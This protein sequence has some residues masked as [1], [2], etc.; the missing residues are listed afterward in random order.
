[1]HTLQSRKCLWP[2][3]A[4]TVLWLWIASLAVVI[5][6][7]DEPIPIPHPFPVPRVASQRSDRF[8]SREDRVRIYMSNW[9]APPCGAESQVLYNYDTS[10]NW[11]TLW[12][13]EPPNV[14]NNQSEYIMESRIEPDQAFFLDR[15]TLMDCLTDGNEPYL[16]RIVFRHNMQMYCRDVISSVLTTWDHTEWET[17]STVPLLL[18]FGD[19][20]YSHI[21]QYLNL[22]LIK[23]FRSATL[24]QEIERVSS[25][26]CVASNELRSHIETPHLSTHLQPIVWKLATHRHF[27]LLERTRAEDTP[28]SKKANMAIFLGQLTGSHLY[29]RD[30]SDLENC[31]NMMRCRLVY[32]HANST[33][34]HA[35]LTSTRNRM[36]KVLNGVQ[37]SRIKVSLDK[38]LKFKGIIMLEGNDVASGLK[39]ALLSQSVVLM[40]YPKHT[41]WA[42][43]ELL[44]P[45]VHYVPLNENATDVEEKMKWVVE[46][47]EAARRISERGTLWMEDLVFH[48]DAQEDDRWIQ[49]EIIRR[50]KTHFLKV[51][52]DA[53]PTANM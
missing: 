13:R 47:D 43:E 37:M 29:D 26:T 40:P 46:N 38:L 8:P 30:K 42:M 3:C 9:Y 17:P 36:P 49:E 19:L 2:C 12:I 1:M 50:Y 48:P 25:K 35:K 4:W 41:S 39:W 6:E 15:N 34:V 51:E 21:Y 44:Q 31:M 23:K 32:T 45:W 24:P 20:S 18:Q 27:G 53:V 5:A 16:D 10:K 7:D 28:W 33:Y 22:P 52:D 11:P 14:G